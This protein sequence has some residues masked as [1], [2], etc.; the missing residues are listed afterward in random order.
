M[1]TEKILKVIDMCC[2]GKKCP[3]ATITQTDNGKIITINDNDQ[4]I[5]LTREQFRN[6]E[7]AL[8]ECERRQ[9]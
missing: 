9:G 3:V 2:G 1:G 5:R 8:L 6:L 7:C 4:T